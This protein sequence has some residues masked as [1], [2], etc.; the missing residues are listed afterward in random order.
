[1]IWINGKRMLNILIDEKVVS[2][3]WYDGLFIWQL[4]RS[5]FGSGAWKSDRPWLGSDKWKNN[6]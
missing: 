5:C 1:M 2:K 4:I 3:M 6:S